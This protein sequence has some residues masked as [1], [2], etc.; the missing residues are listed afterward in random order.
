MEDT[1]VQRT[2]FKDKKQQLVYSTTSEAEVLESN[3]TPICCT[4]F[5]WEIAARIN[6]KD[7]VKKLPEKL[8]VLKKS[9]ANYW[10]IKNC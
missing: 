7:A 8:Q 1:Q 10:Y 4:V 5:E 9:E 2:C 3:P 6:Q